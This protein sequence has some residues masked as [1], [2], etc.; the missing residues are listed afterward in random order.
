MIV[1]TVQ[2]L[3][4]VRPVALLAVLAGCTSPP[5]GE[6]ERS[7]P[8]VGVPALAAGSMLDPER[9]GWFVQD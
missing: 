8:T 1:A 6:V 3:R 2:R 4:M 7:T 9:G 5:P